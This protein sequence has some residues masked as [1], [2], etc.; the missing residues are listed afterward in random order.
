MRILLKRE[1]FWRVGTG[2]GEGADGGE[3]RGNGGHFGAG[4]G[5]GIV[6]ALEQSASVFG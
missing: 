3:G 1:Q 4:F 2:V 6:V 5:K